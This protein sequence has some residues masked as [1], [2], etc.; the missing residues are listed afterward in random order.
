MSLEI[1]DNVSDF[2]N[3][4]FY[5]IMDITYKIFAHIFLYITII[6][7]IVRKIMHQILVCKVVQSLTK[8]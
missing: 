1:C 7:I 8:L 5:Q 6:I 4:K 3:C 2:Q